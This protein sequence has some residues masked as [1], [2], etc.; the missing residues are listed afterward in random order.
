MH[1]SE[2]FAM[3]VMPAEQI[4]LIQSSESFS[5]HVMPAE[6]SESIEPV[7]MPVKKYILQLI[8]LNSKFKL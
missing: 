6:Q 5:W 8:K 2:S 4:E 1:S 3:R 7:A